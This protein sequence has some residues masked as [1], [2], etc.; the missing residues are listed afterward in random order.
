MGR[1]KPE[2]QE[3]H[4]RLSEK[5]RTLPRRPGVYLWKDREGKVLY[6]GKS[7]S[8]RDRV[9][10]Y[11][12]PPE[13]L[14]PRL[15]RLMERAWDLEVFLTETELEALVL[16]ANLIKRHRPRYNILLKDDKTYPYIKVTVQEPWPRVVKTRRLE[17]DGARYF[18][19]YP[20]ARAVD[21]ALEALRRQFP[22]RDCDE[23]MDGRRVR[24][25]LY[26]DLGWCLAPCVGKADP[27]AYR[28]AIE[29]VIRFLEGKGEALLAELEERMWQAARSLE[30][31]RAARLRDRVRALAQLLEQQ[32]VFAPGGEDQDL[33]L[34]AR[35]DGSALI[36][37]FFVRGGRLVGKDT[38]PLEGAEEA[39]EA[40]LLEAFL[41]QFYQDAP[42]LPRTVLLPALPLHAEVLS[43]WLSSRRGERVVLR[44]PERDQEVRLLELA[45]ENLRYTLQELRLAHLDRRQRARA[46]LE[47]LAKALWLP[48]P[49]RRIEGYDISHLQGEAAV[50]SM[51]V[52]LQGRPHKAG[53][54]RFRIRT[55]AGIDDYGMM[56]EVLRR[57]F[58]RWAE[59][60]EG[61]W[62]ELPDLLLVDGGRGQLNVALRVLEEA[63]LRERL[64]VAALAKREE[65]VF[66]P[67]RDE[68][69]RLE[70]SNPALQLLQQV[71]DESHRFARGYHHLLRRKKVRRSRLDEIRGVGPR[72]KQ[73]LLRR[74]GSLAAL[75]QA[76]VEEIA[77][78][79]GISRALAERI[80]KELGEG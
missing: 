22:Y 24:P 55:V 63:G 12:A 5:V 79:P 30:F 77:Q 46:A 69:V 75:R 51:V 59:G 42:Q 3:V 26:Y 66:L 53:Y 40:E 48:A 76:S 68:P 72:R 74:F 71:R 52:F 31:E 54:R 70:R 62:G 2:A 38:F 47:A 50:G 29:G 67:D 23:P 19:P 60:E 49:P 10:S 16:E 21:Q 13:K 32:A 25:C 18:G 1:M 39:E 4:R 8:L 65:E 9:R 58:A 80:K 43:A 27:Q 7:V 36:Q 73:A 17:R 61:E 57:R 28:E 11:L 56:A 35:D 41:L 37:V 6:V 44:L 20:S 14:P 45:R 33:I 64:S 15:R 78:V 34:V